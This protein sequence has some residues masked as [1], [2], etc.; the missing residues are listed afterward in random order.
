MEKFLFKSWVAP[1]IQKFDLSEFLC[2]D[3]W[4]FFLKQL[5]LLKMSLQDDE[6]NYYYFLI[7][8]PE[9][10]NGNPKMI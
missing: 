5:L 10:L 4:F 3:D 8:I 9:V 2:S 6:S 1:A 7:R